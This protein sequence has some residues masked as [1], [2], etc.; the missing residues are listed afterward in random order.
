MKMHESPTEQIA[1][2]EAR[3]DRLQETVQ[4]LEEELRRTKENYDVLR[5]K[6]EC[7]THYLTPG[8]HYTDRV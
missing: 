7:H 5:R 1:G 6:Y 3:L 4:A 2:L 8:C